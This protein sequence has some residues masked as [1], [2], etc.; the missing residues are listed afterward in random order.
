[1]EKYS[2]EVRALKILHVPIFSE[3][4][5]EL[6]IIVF[7]SRLHVSIYCILIRKKKYVALY[8]P[9]VL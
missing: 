5:E 3:N 7:L 2:L 1:M 8:R 4:S 6:H 9:R